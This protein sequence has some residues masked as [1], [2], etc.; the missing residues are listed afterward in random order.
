M[1]D[2]WDPE[3]YKGPPSRTPIPEK[4]TSLPNPVTIIQT[5][6][7][8]SVDAPVTFFREWMERQHAKKKF[9]Y[10]HRNYRRVPDLTECLEDD[11]VCF[12]EAEAQWRRDMKVDQEIVKIIQER[13]GA[14]QQREGHS[15][16]QNCAK[17]M[18][19]FAQVAQAY[20]DRYADLGAHGTARKCLMKQKH[21][22][23]A[24]RKA[25]AEAKD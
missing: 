7:Y 19:Q 18:E 10:Y 5:L 20:Q 6:F 3:V 24:E 9:Y 1:P 22:M 2:D 15:F 12:F 23:I 11:Y 8:Y 4:R 16:V 21:R 14:C 25:Q 13:L 17:E